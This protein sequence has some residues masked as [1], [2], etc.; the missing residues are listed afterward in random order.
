MAWPVPVSHVVLY[1]SYCFEVGYAPATIRLY[2]AAICY[3][4]KLRNWP[5][6]S[7]YFLVKKLLEGCKRLRYSKDTR[8]PITRK[9]LGV[10]C[11][12]L[13]SITFSLYEASLFRAVYCLAYFGLFR[14]SELVVTNMSRSCALHFADMHLENSM[15]ALTIRMRKTKTH[16]AGPPFYIRLPCD[17][18]TNI[19]CVHRMHEYIRVR[20]TGDGFLFRHRDGSPLTRAQFSGVLSKVLHVAGLSS[21][22]YRPHSFRIGRASELAV[23]NV[24]EESIKLMGRWTS[25]AYRRYLRL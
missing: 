7:A 18:N 1:I 12:K 15:Q 19:C 9:V 6:P 2:I 13:P 11:E 24:P 8:I 17:G 16:Q 14:V 22:R 10:I 23:Q 4:H 25:G 20:G 21:G 5:D 3:Q